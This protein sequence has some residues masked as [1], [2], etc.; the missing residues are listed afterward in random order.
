VVVALF[1]ASKHSGRVRDLGGP[2]S[3][4]CSVAVAGVTGIFFNFFYF[5]YDELP[6][7]KFGVI[8]S[9][10]EPGRKKLNGRF[11]RRY[12]TRPMFSTPNTCTSTGDF[13]E[14]EQYT[15]VRRLKKRNRSG[16]CP[17]F[18]PR[19]GRVLDYGDI[20]KSSF[21]KK[22]HVVHPNAAHACSHYSKLINI[23]RP[24]YLRRRPTRPS[25]ISLCPTAT[26]GARK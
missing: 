7:N 14:Y 9:Q 19:S 2:G 4:L 21:F 16:P 24:P 1:P 17:E 15:T 8:H 22:K 18:L 12:R 25:E 10:E 23:R 5:Y 11:C 20:T 26:T 6:S 13:S 3:K